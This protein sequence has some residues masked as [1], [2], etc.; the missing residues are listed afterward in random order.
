MKMADD[1]KKMIF[2]RKEVPKLYKQWLN[3]D[4]KNF[5]Q[6]YQKFQEVKV[7]IPRKELDE[8]IDAMSSILSDNESYTSSITQSKIQADTIEER[9]STLKSFVQMK[10]K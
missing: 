3:L 4:T 8:N 6:S 9:I 1:Q 10:R 5:V 7:E 2:L